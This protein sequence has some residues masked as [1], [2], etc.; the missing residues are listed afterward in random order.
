MP[1]EEEEEEKNNPGPSLVSLEPQKPAFYAKPAVEDS[2]SEGPPSYRGAAALPPRGP[3]GGPKGNDNEAE[4]LALANEK[5]LQELETLSSKMETHLQRLRIPAE[6]RSPGSASA[7]S[8][9]F[10]NQDSRLKTVD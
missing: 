5:L 9:A 2:A 3:R 1:E 4:R 8:E 10:W 7:V 6:H